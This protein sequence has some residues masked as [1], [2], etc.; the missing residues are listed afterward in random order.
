MKKRAISIIII[1]IIALLLLYLLIKLEYQELLPN[2][3]I[4][5]TT[6]FLCP[7]C[8]GTRCVVFMLQGKWIQ[9][10][11]SHMIFFMGILYLLILNILIIINL[12]KEKKVANWLYP[13]WW[14]AIIFAIMW[15]GYAILRNII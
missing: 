1:E 13:K 6:G 14:Y 9:A 7:A 4:Y 15:L 11:F 8:G 10:F 5:Q 12:N 3:W 2:C